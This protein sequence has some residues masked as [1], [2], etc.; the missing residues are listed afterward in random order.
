MGL[1][2]SMTH[3]PNG[4]MK[5]KDEIVFVYLLS[6]IGSTRL[7]YLTALSDPSIK[8]LPRR[9]TPFWPEINLRIMMPLVTATDGELDFR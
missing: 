6:S 4:K 1:R 9:Q 8:Q 7:F 2:E 5:L 3:G